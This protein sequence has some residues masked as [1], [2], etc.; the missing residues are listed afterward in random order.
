MHFKTGAILCKILILFSP[1]ISRSLPVGPHFSELVLGTLRMLVA[2][3]QSALVP[4]LLH[5]ALCPI[6]RSEDVYLSIQERT[7]MRMNY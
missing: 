2:W 3:Q 6:P 1:K 5:R 4:S 7:K